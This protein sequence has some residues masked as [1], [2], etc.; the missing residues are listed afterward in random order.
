MSPS[1]SS[2]FGFLI[3]HVGTRQLGLVVVVGIAVAV[4]ARR[5]LLRVCPDDDLG[6]G[7]VFMCV[8]L[9]VVCIY[10]CSLYVV[11]AL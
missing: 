6:M 10:I 8:S 5:V 2:L 3:L 9:T 11:C 1:L 4:V 7:S